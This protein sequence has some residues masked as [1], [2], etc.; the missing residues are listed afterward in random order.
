MAE[1]QAD[2]HN[3]LLSADAIKRVAEARRK[4]ES[5]LKQAISCEQE[6]DNAA[7]YVSAFSR[8]ACV[9]F[10]ANAIELMDELIVRRKN[11]SNFEAAL[12]ESGLSVIEGIN[13]G[14]EPRQTQD[15]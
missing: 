10:D 8:F 13:A 6:S 7:T 3:V 11:K 14:P 1:D 5:D 15:D 9:L 12:K 4:A 2:S